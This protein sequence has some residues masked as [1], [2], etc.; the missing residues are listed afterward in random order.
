MKLKFDY[1]SKCLL[2]CLFFVGLSSLAFGQRT[3]T[4]TV[5]DAENGE[6]LIGASVLVR[7]TTTGTIT[8]IDGSYRLTVPEGN[9]EVEV[10]YTG[11]TASVI[12][13]GAANVLDVALAPGTLL[14]EVVV[15]GYGTQKAKEVTSAIASLDTDDFN[16]GNVNDP[17][18]LVQGK[19]AGLSI[20]RPGGDP[21]G[22]STIRLRGLSTLGANTSPLIVIDGVIGA[23]LETVDPNDIASIDVLKDGSAAAIYGTRASSGVIIITTK[24]GQEGAARVEYNGYVSAESVSR[25]VPVASASEFAQYRP[26]SDR[27]F[28]TNWLDEVTETGISNAHNLSIS[29]G[30]ASTTYRASVNFRDINGIGLNSGFDQLNGRLGITQKALNDRLTLSI[31]ATATNRDASYGLREAFR[32]ATTYNPTAPTQIQ[33]ETDPLFDTYG[34]YYQEVN[35][36]YFNPLA[37][38][39]QSTNIGNLRDFLVSGRADYKLVEGLTAGVFYSA[40]RE[41]DAFAEYYQKDAY[42]RGINRN[43]LAKRVDQIKESQLFELTGNYDLEFGNN[44]LDV[45]LGYSYQDFEFSELFVEAGNFISDDLTF[46]RFDAAQDFADARATVSSTRNNYKVIAFFGRVNLNFDN[47]YFLS[48]SL[49][50][51]G[52]TRFG[53][54]NKWQMFPGVSAGVTLSNL[55]DVSGIDNLKLR[56]GYGETGNLPPESYLSFLRFEPQGSFFYNGGFVPALAPSRNANPDLR[57]ETKGEFDVG[58]D[59]AFGDYFLTGSVDY[60]NRRTRDLLYQVV[61]PVPPNLAPTTWANLE[62]VV[63]RN[64][65]FEATLGLNVGE[66]GSS[67]YWNPSLVFSTYN[68]ILDTLSVEDPTFAFFS[69]GDAFKDPLTAPGAPGLNDDPTTA[70]FPGQELGQLWGPQFVEVGEDGEFVFAD[71]NGDGMVADIV[72][73][74]DKQVIGNGLPDFSLGFANTFSFGNLSLSFFLRGDFGHDLANLYRVFY[75]P[76]GSRSIDNLVIT[77]YFD[78]NLTATPK[79]SSYY[80]EDASYVV[81]D[82]ASLSYTFDL[83]EDSAFD[84][85]RLYVTGQN[86]FWITNYSGSDPTPRYADPGRADNGGRYER[87]FNP[88]PLAPGIDR[89]NSYFNSRTIL[90][91]VNVGF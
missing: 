64:S 76:L 49:R 36:D 31:D 62:D 83:A 58:L 55:F 89:R 1:L 33:S 79:F 41:N 51:E 22:S 46:N 23:S 6:P 75:E 4:G 16:V 14:D 12:E 29:G 54:N 70:V 45:L 24:K 30:S 32:Y 18:Q 78:E 69:S 34:G 91:G 17:T 38:A 84:K 21:N 44:G 85:L 27:G 19:V 68:T 65:G 37:I 15:V 74:E 48:A 28:S 63:L 25:R 9:D 67:F 88:S 72:G 47:T 87:E 10:S 80:V 52:S 60:Y 35:F 66:E 20:A 59:F 8:D 7:G 77:E 53:A 11:Y 42:F 56:V 43:G 57:W 61:V 39:E 71:L 82:N 2:L 26:G 73:E 40:L 90:F 50:Q 3:I 86:L 81:L 13:L 5:T